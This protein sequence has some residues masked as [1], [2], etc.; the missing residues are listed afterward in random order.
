MTSK[1]KVAPLVAPAATDAYT[2]VTVQE[3]RDNDKTEPLSLEEIDKHITRD[4]EPIIMFDNVLTMNDGFAVT[5]SDI[6]NS[7]FIPTPKTVRR[8]DRFP[9]VLLVAKTINGVPLARPLV[10]L[11]DTGSTGCLMKRSALPH[12]SQ[13]IE[14]RTKTV[15]T[16]TQG[17]HTCNEIA[18]VNAATLPEFDA[19]RTI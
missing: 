12:G 1:P 16:T 14:T 18:Y 9:I 2:I 10:C 6:D 4:F 8:A 11:L 15:H 17:N 19:Q 13:A 3:D 7:V 5:Q